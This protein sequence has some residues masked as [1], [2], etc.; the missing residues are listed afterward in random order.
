[1]TILK[2]IIQ[3]YFYL[4]TRK[5]NIELSKIYLKEVYFTWN[6]KKYF[7]LSFQNDKGGFE[8]RNKYF[9]GSNSPKYY[10][11]IKGNNSKSLNIF[12][13]FFDFL[14]ALTYYKAQT[15]GNDTIILNSL[16]FLDK[17]LSIISKYNAI[18]LYLDNDTAGKKAFQIISKN[19]TRTMNHS[20][21]LFLDYKD[22]NEFL[23]K[24]KNHMSLKS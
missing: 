18:N 19:H 1:M 23:C 5:I 11:T 10:T 15:P 2:S 3:F 9:K 21:R 6:D 14:S 20:E 12:E 13:G 24:G 17:I 7:A 16:A 8:L 4:K 22:F